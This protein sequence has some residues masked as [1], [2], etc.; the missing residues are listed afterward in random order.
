M[1]IKLDTQSGVI[2]KTVP[3]RGFMFVSFGERQLF[4][5][6]KQWSEI[7][8]PKVGQQ[9]AY[10]I[11]PSKD[12][13]YKWEAVNARPASQDVENGASALASPQLEVK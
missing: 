12:P 8:Y 11:A 6:L 1:S 10:D 5:H 4:L 7:E 13:R 9:I 2:T 3:E